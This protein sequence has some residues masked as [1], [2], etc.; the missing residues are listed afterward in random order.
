[1]ANL[2]ALTN[3]YPTLSLGR[4]ERLIETGESRARLTVG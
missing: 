4:G 1:M 2:L 3:A